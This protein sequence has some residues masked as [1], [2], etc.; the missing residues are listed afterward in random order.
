MRLLLFLIVCTVLLLPRPVRSAPTLWDI[1][2]IDTMKYSR[3]EARTGSIRS[4][5]PQLVGQIKELGATHLSIGTPYNDEFIPILK[6]W[7]AEA[8][9]NGLSVW[10]RGN[11][12]EWE[13]WFGYPKFSDIE[14][15]HRRTK[16]FILNHPDLFAEGDIFTP[17]PEAENGVISDPRGSAQKAAIHNAFLVKS[18]N[19]CVDAFS[20]IKINATCG[21]FSMNA[22]IAKQVLTKETVEKT[23]NVVVIDHYVRTSAQI[24]ED[25]RFLNEKFGVPIVFGEFGAP[26]PDLNG[27][28]NQDEQSDFVRELL[29]EMY[30]EKSFVK[31]MNYWTSVSGSTEIITRDGS[32]RKAAGTLSD[33][34]KPA[35][36]RGKITTPFGEPLSGALIRQQG[37]PEDRTTQEDG[38]Y[39]IVSP[40]QTVTVEF[41]K[42][43][44]IPVS[45]S[46]TLTKGKETGLDVKLSP[47]N[48]DF[49][50]TIRMFLQTL[51]GIVRPGRESNSQPTP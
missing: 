23:G 13:G 2:A 29:Q 18:Y 26:I 17:A 1:Q 48:P 34:Y 10:F 42:E 6:V 22:D 16:D 14:E 39:M 4:Q 33:F 7:V 28:M 30:K 45:R 5:I 8:R 25:I 49:F 12:A 11:W 32:L 43:G 27:T 47:S 40:E 51:L 31:G 24:G 38:T 15:H 44:Y 3:D 41:Q 36:V 50:F 9:K 46:L 19:T 35:V 21:Y 20:Q 37:N